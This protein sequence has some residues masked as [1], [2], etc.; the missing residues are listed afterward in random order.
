MNRSPA[1]DMPKVVNYTAGQL[2]HFVSQLFVAARVTPVEADRI[3]E[4][5]VESN[6][7]GHDSHGIVLAGWYL[8]QIQSG[9]LQPGAPLVVRRDLPGALVCDAGLGFGQVQCREFVNRCCEKAMTAGAVCGTLTRCGHIGRLG[10]W[11]EQAAKLGFAALIAVNDNGAIYTVAPPGGI[12]RRLSTN[13]IGIGIPTEDEP[14]V[15]DM[16]TSAVANGKLKIARLAQRPVPLGWIQDAEGNPTTDP[17]VMLADPPGSLLPFGGD[18]AYKGFGLGLVFDI[19]AAGLSGGFCPPA[20]PGALEWNNVL[21][22]VWNPGQFAGREHFL[23]EAERLIAFVRSA[24]CKPGVDQIQ[25]PGDRSLECRRDRLKN[26]LPLSDEY[27]R[28]L[29]EIAGKLGVEFPEGQEPG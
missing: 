29:K 9:E 7:R 13:P 22:V 17:E 24:R 8:S 26:G 23:T 15:L 21:L 11:V 18:Q 2:R 4:S 5:L 3:A 12:D 1:S 20:E 28:P 16:S 27:L 19:L 10:E 6:L 25:L 14:L